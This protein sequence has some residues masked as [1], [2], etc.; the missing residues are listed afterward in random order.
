MAVEATSMTPGG[1]PAPSS[2]Q[3]KPSITPAMGFTASDLRRQ[4]V[5]IQPAIANCR[6]CRGE[7]LQCAERCRLCGNPLWKYEWLVAVD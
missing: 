7:V 2:A 4:Q 1:L 6:E 5:P 3:R